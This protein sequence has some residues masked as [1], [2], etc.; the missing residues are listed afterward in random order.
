MT[1]TS[2]GQGKTRSFS[3]NNEVVLS[4]KF[5]MFNNGVNSSHGSHPQGS[6]KTNSV[7]VTT[8]NQA[9]NGQILNLFS[10]NFDSIPNGM[11]N[12]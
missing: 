4:N 12:A 3:R 8:T 6:R 2:K 5:K 1:T 9:N 7:P 11:Q 10:K